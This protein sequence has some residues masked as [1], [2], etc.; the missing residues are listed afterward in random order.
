MHMVAEGHAMLSRITVWPGSPVLVTCQ[1]VPFQA[2]AV[3]PAA[4][5]QLLA[6]LHDR[7]GG[8][9]GGMAGGGSAVQAR[10]FHRRACGP[11]DDCDSARQ[12]R[13]LVQE[14]CR[15]GDGGPGMTRQAVPFQLSASEAPI[16]AG[17]FESPSATQYPS[18]AHETAFSNSIFEIRVRVQVRPFHRLTG[19]GLTPTSVQSAGL[20]HQIPSFKI[21][22]PG[23]TRHPVPF[24]A[25]AA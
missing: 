19:S 8:W 1:D 5:T 11:G 12:N 4:A 25:T 18:L 16:R 17:L 10:P 6:L 7:A 2:A 15:A 9:F 21:P 22:V 20:V 14:I 3:L 24:H 13:V 23:S